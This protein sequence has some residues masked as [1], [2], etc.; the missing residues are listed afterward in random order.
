M[1]RPYWTYDF[2]S[3]E[4]LKEAKEYFT[5][6]DNNTIENLYWK[7]IQIPKTITWLAKWLGKG[8]NYINEKANNP[9][10]QGMIHYI[11]SVIE[12]D[13]EEKAML[14]IYNPTIASKNLSANFNWRETTVNENI[15]IDTTN[16]LSEEQ[17]KT[18]AKRFNG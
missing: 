7:K 1:A 15:N 2:S 6:C 5:Y 4:L 16:E 11:R 18:I 9:D 12:N 14:W 10:Y 3:D 17:K 8:K 13:I